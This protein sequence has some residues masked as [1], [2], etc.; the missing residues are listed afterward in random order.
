[1]PALMPVLRVCHKITYSFAANR[2][3]TVAALK[4]QRSRDREG[5]VGTVISER[6]LRSRLPSTADILPYR[7]SVDEWRRYSNRG[8]RVIQLQERLSRYPGLKSHGAVILANATAGLTTAMLPSG[9]LSA[10]PHARRAAGMKTWFHDVDRGT[11][12]LHPNEVHWE[13]SI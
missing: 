11:W 8:P 4:A 1:M 2:S 9:T 10:T 12:A 7:Q 5:A 13:G 6:P 3:L